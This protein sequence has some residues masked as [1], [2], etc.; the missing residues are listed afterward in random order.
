MKILSLMSHNV[1]FFPRL[2]EQE[3]SDLSKYSIHYFCF[4]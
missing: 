1:F 3:D 4:P 2:Q